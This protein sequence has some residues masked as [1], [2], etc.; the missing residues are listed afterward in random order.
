MANHERS[1][2]K[3]P[4]LLLSGLLCD[5]TVWADIPE[6]LGD[7]A[8]VRIISFRGFSS[9]PAMAEHVLAMAPERFAVAG[10]SMGGRVALEVLRSAPRRVSGLALLNTGVHTVRDGEP[11]SRGR[12]LRLASEHGMSALAAEWLPPMMAYGSARTAELM[13][14]L[15]AMVE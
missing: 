8:G 9:I 13:P 12:L 15:L 14:R 5:E 4:L 7:A 3:H 6:R 10:H 2:M 1:H 11:E